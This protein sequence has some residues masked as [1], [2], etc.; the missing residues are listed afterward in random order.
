LRH[1]PMLALILLV[2]A[3]PAWGSAS[4]SPW[5]KGATSPFERSVTEIARSLVGTTASVECADRDGWQA[6]AASN[7][8]DPVTT[9]A[10]TPLYRDPGYGLVRP[11]GRTS[12]SPRTCRLAYAFSTSPTEAGARICRH[13]TATRWATVS[14]GRHDVR[15]VRRPVRAPVLGECDDWGSKLVAVH[16]IGHE[17]MHL[18]GAVG[19]AAADCLAVQID[20]FVA[21]RLGATTAFARA[22]SREY[23]RIY[24]PTQDPRY[25]SAECRDGGALDLFPNRTGW[26]TP[27]AYPKDLAHVVRSLAE[28]T[29]AA[30]SL[31]GT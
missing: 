30:T 29:G 9:W 20:A 14:A 27:G 15:R 17:S 16:V 28:A 18:A 6:L 12:L 1:L 22:L 31:D 5:S 7:G 3:T 19:E 11:E 8:F 21:E 23:W 2:C 4:A 10:M 26:P 13:G 25:R 24:Y